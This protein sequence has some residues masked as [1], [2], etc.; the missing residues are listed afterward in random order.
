MSTEPNTAH[1]VP[2]IRLYLM[3]ALYL[4]TFISLTYDNWSTIFFPTE[5]LDTLSGVAISFWASYGL[6]M[7]LGV[8]YPLKMLPLILLQLF[9]KAGW[10]IGTYL[11]AKSADLLNEDLEAFY[12]IC[13]TAVIVDTLVI[14][15]GYVWR[16]YVLDFVNFRKP[17]T[18]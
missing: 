2:K 1:E 10:L 15:W 3:R 11:P 8:R 18:I 12:W 14:P 13:V 17:Q 9:Y 5:Q 4:L 16:T 7:G 6:L